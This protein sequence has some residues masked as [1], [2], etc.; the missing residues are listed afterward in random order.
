MEQTRYNDAYS[1]GEGLI[2]YGGLLKVIGIVLGIL[3]GLVAFG[4]AS[5]HP[6]IVLMSLVLA[7]FIGGTFYSMGI[8]ISGIGQMLTASLDTAVNTA[9]LKDIKDLLSE[10][11]D[12]QEAIVEN[13]GTPSKHEAV[14]RKQERI[15]ISHIPSEEQ[16]SS[17]PI[18][19]HINVMQRYLDLEENAVIAEDQDI[20]NDTIPIY[21]MRTEGDELTT[22][23]S[24]EIF[25]CAYCKKPYKVNTKGGNLVFRCIKCHHQM[26]VQISHKND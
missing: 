20:E 10:K 3:M 23:E 16:S 9:L 6:T 8:F 21:V 15:S 4:G 24:L 18:S 19:P 7:V 5:I 12:H 2:G 25:A 13:K 26:L 17:Q 14:Q 1:V 22:S 11:N